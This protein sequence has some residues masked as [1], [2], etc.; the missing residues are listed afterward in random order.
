MR[1]LKMFWQVVRK[2]RLGIALRL[3]WLLWLLPESDREDFLLDLR[4]L[5]RGGTLRRMY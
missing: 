2:G 1:E 3:L 5:N 4:Y